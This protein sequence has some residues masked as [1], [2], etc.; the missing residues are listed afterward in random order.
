MLR[1]FHMTRQQWK[2]LVKWSVYGVFFL[3]LLLLQTVVAAKNPVFGIKLCLIP[4]FLVCVCIK[5]GPEAGGLFALIG[6]VVWCLSGSD[7]GNLTIV[8]LT[9]CAIVSSVL[10]RTLLNDRLLAVWLCVLSSCLINDSVIFLFKIILVNIDV[11]NFW[12]ILLPGAAAS[13]VFSLVIYPLV[14]LIHRIG[15]S[16]G[17]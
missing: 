8:T 13:S 3:I 5:E 14:R 17:I 15:G 10:C 7:Y 16:N 11:R 2:Q 9:I 12:R 1:Y 6:S 4:A